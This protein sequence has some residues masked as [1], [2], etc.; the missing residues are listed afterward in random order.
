MPPD[1]LGKRLEPNALD[2]TGRFPQA[3]LGQV[4]RRLVKQLLDAR[5]AEQFMGADQN[6]GQRPAL[7]E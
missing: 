7:R 5:L 2:L 1:E 3:F 4:R 6:F